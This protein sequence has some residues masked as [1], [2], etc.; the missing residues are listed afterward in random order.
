[1][2]VTVTSPAPAVTSGA[3]SIEASAAVLSRFI[4]TTAPTPMLSVPSRLAAIAVAEFS[5]VAFD[6]GIRESGSR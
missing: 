1:M 3:S 5:M 6:V 2:A 4:V